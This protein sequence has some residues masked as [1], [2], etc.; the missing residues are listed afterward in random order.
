MLV[1]GTSASSLRS[2]L[3]K[4]SNASFLSA[5]IMHVNAGTESDILLDHVYLLTFI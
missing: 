4:A 1:D 5:L 2:N 3:L